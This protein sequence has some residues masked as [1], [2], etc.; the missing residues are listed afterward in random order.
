MTS[1]W[2]VPPATGDPLVKAAWPQA[3]VAPDQTSTATATARKTAMLRKDN[4]FPAG[5]PACQCRWLRWAWSSKMTSISTGFPPERD[6]PSY[7]QTFV[8]NA[9]VDA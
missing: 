9:L 1:D 7:L 8:V 3:G 2:S 5:R 4:M 6:L